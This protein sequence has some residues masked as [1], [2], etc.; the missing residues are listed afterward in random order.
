MHIAVLSDPNNFHTQKWATALLAAGARVTVFSFDPYHDEG[1]ETVCLTNPPGAK[2]NYTSYLRG[3]KLLAEALQ[4]H[5]IDVVNALN[6]TPFGVWARQ[7]GFRPLIQ[8]ALGADILEYPPP[9]KGSPEL[10]YRSWANVQGDSGTLPR[11]KHRILRRFYRR[12]VARA[13]AAGDLVTGDNQYLV[14]CIRDWFGVAEEKVRLLRWGVE[15]KLFEVTPEQL[16]DLRQRLGLKAGKT[17]VLSPRGAKAIYQGDIILE[18][19]RRLLEGNRED[20]QCLMLSAG[21]EI[22]DEVRQK[23]LELAER[24]QRFVFVEE[25]LPREDV[26]ALWNLV[27]IFV[28]APIYDGYSASVAEG[29]YVGAIPVLND[30]PANKELFCHGENGWICDPFSP[31]NL[32]ADLKKIIE[33]L[34]ELKEKFASVNKQWI[35]EHSL[36]ERNAEKFMEWAENLLH[37]AK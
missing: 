1:L 11:M 14:D 15:E 3:G 16:D 24:D 31:E 12:Q 13:L 5:Q 37:R 10:S 33:H 35:R 27:D 29:R 2:Y 20:I 18:G 34:P 25:S 7:S 32:A 26:Y 22:A 21:Y 8:S 6:I 30:I 36:V 9:G 19:F 17:L 4:H 23:A 28:S